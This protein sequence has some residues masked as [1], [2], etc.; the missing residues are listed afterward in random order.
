MKYYKQQQRKIPVIETYDVIVCGGGPAGCAAAIAAARLGAKTALVEKNGYLGGATVSQMVAVVLSTN[1]VDFQG[2][3]HEYTARLSKYDGF[4]GITESAN[5]YYPKYKWLRG[6][7]DPEQVKRV[8]Q[9]LVLESGVDLF[10]YGT[11]I[12]VFKDKSSIEGVEVY[13]KGTRQVLLGSYIIDATGDGDIANLADCSWH[14]GQTAGLYTQETSLV[15]RCT[16]NN[17][18]LHLGKRPE[19]CAR[20]DIKQVDT[21]DIKDLTRATASLR[22][23]I[24]QKLQTKELIATANDLGVRSSRIVQGKETISNQDAWE[25]TKKINSI[26][27][28]SWELDVHPI[29]TDPVDPHLY[30]SKS[31]IYTDRLQRISNHEWF[32][33][34]FG[35]LCAKGI[36]NLLL[37]GRIISAEL[38]AHGSLRIQQTCMS[39]GESA[40]VIAAM[41]ADSKPIAIEEVSASAVKFIKQLRSENQKYI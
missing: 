15:Y 9:E 41:A 38:W 20:V 24:W 7:V 10:Y 17:T 27:K 11:V 13:C 29:G 16:G 6:S 22:E 19:K 8:W 28:C 26:A 18:H 32:D 34:P 4:S 35:A 23:D 25:L 21:L 31:K 14:R 37:A 5:S 12:D 2:I 36:D 3:W 1:G 33:I 30:H 40:G 39:T